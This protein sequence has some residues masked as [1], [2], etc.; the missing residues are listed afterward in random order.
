MLY[1]IRSNSQPDIIDY[2]RKHTVTTADTIHIIRV[3]PRGQI[4]MSARDGNVV[5]TDD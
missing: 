2:T 5:E 3:Q 1:L 4:V